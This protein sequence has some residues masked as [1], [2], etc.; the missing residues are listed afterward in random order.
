MIAIR[1]VDAASETVELIRGA[2]LDWHRQGRDLDPGHSGPDAL[3][4]NDLLDLAGRIDAGWQSVDDERLQIEY[5]SGY[6]EGYAEAKEE[7][8]HAQ[9][10]E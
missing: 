10:K 1:P 2:L 3:T 4:E 9:N 7:A 6:E 8:R 5:R